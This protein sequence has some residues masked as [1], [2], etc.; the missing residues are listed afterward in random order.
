[1]TL[2]AVGGVWRYALDLAAGLT[3][4]GIHVHLVGLGPRPSEH[5][6]QELVARKLAPPIWLDDPL[7]WMASGAAELWPLAERLQQLADE[8]DVDLFHLNLP[9]QAQGLAVG[10]PVVVVSHSCLATWWQAVKGTPLPARLQWH[11]ES[12]Q[13]GFRRADIVLAPSRSHAIALTEVYGPIDGLQVV[14]N[15]AGSPPPPR[16]KEPVV[17][18]AARWWDEGKNGR[19]LDAAA[20][21]SPWPVL[22]AGALRGPEGQVCE[23]HHAVALGQCSAPSLRESMAR[24]AIFAA[25]SRFEPFGLA[26]LEA[27][28]AGAALVLA[29]IPTFRE[30]WQDTALFVPPDDIAGFSKAFGQLAVE[31]E[32]RR[33]LGRLARMK[34]AELSQERQIDGLLAAYRRATLKASLR[35][36]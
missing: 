1:M 34:A 4:R 18:A 7:D 21:S 22:M 25:P 19:T 24:A 15:A 5:Q 30:L 12:Q 28:L 6:Y 29:D 16:A 23:L 8:N 2:D 11:A 17:L 10:R 20:R 9:S 13:G 27:A 3:Q 31:T 36:A 35:A 26:V 14:H 32:Q 33:L